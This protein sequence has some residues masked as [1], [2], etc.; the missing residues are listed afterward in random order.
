MAKKL[1]AKEIAKQKAMQLAEQER[2]RQQK[3][4]TTM[5]SV[6]AVLVV[7]FFGAVYYVVTKDERDEKAVLNDADSKPSVFNDDGSL[8]VSLNG[9]GKENLPEG[10]ENLPTLEVFHDYICPACGYFDRTLGSAII[11]LITSGEVIYLDHPIALFDSTSKDKYSTRATAVALYLAEYAPQAYFQYSQSLFSTEHQPSEG[12]KYVS[13]TNEALKTRAIEAGA[14][15][16]VAEAAI[17]SG[18]TTDSK[19]T[20]WL[21]IM[22]NKAQTLDDNKKWDED[23]QQLIF[24]TPLIKINGKVIDNSLLADKASGNFTA[25]ALRAALGLPPVE[26]AP[27]E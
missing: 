8:Y 22:S 27:A 18:L 1:S 15:P 19:F 24:S 12:T 2:Q 26:E 17:G 21:Q 16:D 23:R 14:D 25:A 7:V 10:S 5:L 9:L 13:V 20:K 4:R 3:A 6:I 11:D